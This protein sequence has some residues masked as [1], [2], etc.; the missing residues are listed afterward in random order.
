MG[1]AYV[2]IASENTSTVKY[3]SKK[4]K[5]PRSKENIALRKNAR[6]TKESGRGH[7][8]G[9]IATSTFPTASPTCL[10]CDDGPDLAS[11][12]T[13][14]LN[15]SQP[16]P[17]NMITP[18]SSKDKI[19]IVPLAVLVSVLALALIVK[20]MLLL[21]SR[22]L[23]ASTNPREE[24]NN[25]VVLDKQDEMQYFDAVVNDSETSTEDS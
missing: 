1:T 22:M 18:E 24:Q 3:T 17:G 7:V 16:M 6:N 8:A 9:T 14:A 5:S 13:A 19:H 4:P 20:G 11:M 25:D 12:T 15:V 23:S 10:E 2:D 21:R